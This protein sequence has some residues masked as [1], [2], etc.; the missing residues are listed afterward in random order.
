MRLP[1]RAATVGQMLLRWFVPAAVGSALGG[2]VLWM[3][4]PAAGPVTVTSPVR[5]TATDTYLG[6]GSVNHLY[7][8]SLL[9]APSHA[10]VL[11]AQLPA[12]VRAAAAGTTTVAEA[13]PAA[14]LVAAAADA[15]ARS[16]A[17]D[18]APTVPLFD[19]E[20]APPAGAAAT[21]AGL[22]WALGHLEQALPGD[23]VAVDT[24]TYANVAPDGTL[25]APPASSSAWAAARAQGAGLLLVG[26]GG[27]DGIAQEVGGESTMR[28]V[29]VGTL[30]EAVSVLCQAGG[31]GAACAQ[32]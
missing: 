31:S 10:D 7:A 2:L 15:A 21:G 9:P 17:A 26:P 11:A 1:V 24:V 22:G 32:P 12:R 30:T 25:S 28:V 18:H 6:G 5:F 14:A 19:A 16:W 3:L 4:A 23:L 8:A 20:P 13:P 27:Y 29:Q